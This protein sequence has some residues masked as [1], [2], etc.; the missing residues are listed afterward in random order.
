MFNLPNEKQFKDNIHGY[1]NLPTVLVENIIDTDWF[2]RLRYINQTGMQVLY[3][4]AKH[5]RY[6][7]SL[8]VYHLGN[9]AI[10][11]LIENFK[12]R[13]ND[14]LSYWKIKSDNSRYVFWAKHKVLFLIACLLHDIGHA[15]FSHALEEYYCEEMLL[16]QKESKLFQS[17]VQIPNM[18]GFS[19]DLKAVE[20]PPA[21]HELMSAFIVHNYYKANVMAVLEELRKSKFPESFDYIDA[22]YAQAFPSVNSSQIENDLEFIMRCILGL[23]YTNYHPELQILNC[24]VELLNGGNFDVDKLDYIIRDTK[25]SGISNIDIDVQRLLSSLTIVYSTLYKNHEFVDG[26]K[27]FDGTATIKDFRSSSSG[28]IRIVG[29]IDSKIDIAS[30]EKVCIC[31]DTVIEKLSGEVN[32]EPGIF[33]PWDEERAEIRKDSEIVVRHKSGKIVLSGHPSGEPCKLDIRWAKVIDDDF[34]FYSENA[35]SVRLHENFDITINGI[36]KLRSTRLKG[37]ILGKCEFLE[38]FGDRLFGSIPSPEA[39]HAFSVGYKKQAINIVSNVLDARNYLYLWT[40]AHHKVVYYTNFLIPELS[41]KAIQ[42]SE[43]V[44]SLNELF[45]PESLRIID[46]SYLFTCIKK[47]N[48]ANLDESFDILRQ[49]LLT[50]KYSNSLYK[51]AHEYDRLFSK[52]S[53]ERRQDIHRFLKELSDIVSSKYG[54]WSSESL[55]RLE[56]PFITNMVWVDMELNRKDSDPHRTYISYPNNEIEILDRIPIV[57][58]SLVKASYDLTFYFYLYYDYDETKWKTYCNTNDILH[59]DINVT[60]REKIVDFFDKNTQ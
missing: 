37:N 25:T 59:N 50:R 8:G 17:L 16:N 48:R 56:L 34:E 19:D 10:D 26:D 24:F 31:K 38:I 41:K 44:S 30:A 40:Y 47:T 49:Q 18:S 60:I 35:T 51:S 14:S 2:Q 15:P 22:E 11:S 9:I 21:P 43:A 45:E 32:W 52:F 46:D 1:I 42:E 12:S 28:E 58:N 6:S 36:V 29:E 4:S 33:F 54:V 23:P 55:N 3:P 5:D 39:Y 53:F 13:E 27:T 7:H 20:N 57:G